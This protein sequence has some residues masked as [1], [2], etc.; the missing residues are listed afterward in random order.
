VSTPLPNPGAAQLL[1]NAAF[2]RRAMDGEE[3]AILAHE[4]AI[5]AGKDVGGTVSLSPAQGKASVRHPTRL[6]PADSNHD[7]IFTDGSFVFDP[8][9]SEQPVSRSAYEALIRQLNDETVEITFYR[10]EGVA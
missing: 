5:A 1:S 10:A 2:V 9:Y 3:C 7:Q 8:Y 4:L 6:G